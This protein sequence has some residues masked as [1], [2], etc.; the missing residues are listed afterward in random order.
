[1]MDIPTY[2]SHPGMLLGKIQSG[3]TKTFLAIMGL[4]FDNDYQVSI[5]LTKGTRALAMQTQQR[6]Q[7][8]FKPFVDS[9]DVLV[10]DIMNM[11]TKLTGYELKSKLVIVVK[12]Q[13]DNLSKMLKLYSDHNYGLFDKKTLIIDDEADYA[14]V[15]YKNSEG[16]V[17][18]NLTAVE[19]DKLRNVANDASFLQ[20]TATP[21]ALYLQPENVEV[22]GNVFKPVRPAFTELVPVNEAY[23]GSDYYFDDCDDQESLANKLYIPLKLPELTVLKK[24]DRRRLKLEEVLTSPAIEGLRSAFINF[25]VGGAIR[26]VQLSASGES[27][28]KL[29]FLVHTEVARAS[30]AWQQEIVE[31]LLEQLSTEAATTSQLFKGLVKQGYDELSPSVEQSGFF[32]PTFKQVTSRVKAGLVDGEVLI[33]SVNSDKQVEELLDDSGQLKLRTPLNIFIGGQILDRGITIGNLIGFYYGRRPQRF[34]QDTV[35][36]HSR[37][38]GYRP[39]EDLAVTRFYTE[40]TI[41]NAMRRM[42]ESDVALR[43]EIESNPDQGIIFIQGSSSGAVVPCSPNKILLS[44]TTTLKSHK[45]IIPVGF[46]TDYKS[47]TRPITDRIDG[48][49]A[50]VRSQGSGKDAFKIDT[51]LAHKI[52]GEAE[53]AIKMSEEEGYSFNWKSMHAAID[54]MAGLSANPNE[55]WC[56]W[57]TNRNNNRLAGVGS[58]TKYVATPDTASTEGRLAKETAKDSPMLMLFRQNGTE[59]QGWMG[60]P[61]YW[62]LLYTSG[63]VPTTIYANET[64]DS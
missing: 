31:E 53:Q 26:Q 44:E 39:K 54:Y 48:L 14:S 42:H 10:F 21:Y 8:D 17:D 37:M 11:P 23:V 12:K 15:G 36:Q 16:E 49:L 34:Q 38:Y 64:I 24:S 29:S 30:H 2:G 7:K 45:R 3:K 5:V 47:Y 9:D 13:K 43:E 1:M 51:A 60:S 50:A 27:I 63:N 25:I 18:A 57:L 56:L 32:L 6:I 33:T 52:L 40:P 58:H 46:Q 19:L 35:L 41:Y 59:E 4:A 55:I 61:F 22:R 62:P 20:V 28:R